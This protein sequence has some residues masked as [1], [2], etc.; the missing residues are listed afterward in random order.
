MLADLFQLRA[1]RP[2]E[3]ERAF[4][5]EVSVRQR[6]PRNPKVEKLILV[7]W[8]LI[9]VKHV[10]VIWAVH[11]YAV[12][13]NQLWINAPTFLLGLLATAVYYLHD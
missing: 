7:C 8:G 13:F 4:I 9:A 3:Y 2:A 1:R 12:P 5:E 6:E 11:H 10:A